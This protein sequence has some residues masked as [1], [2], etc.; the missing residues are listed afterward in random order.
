MLI[1]SHCHLSYDGFSDFILSRN[2]AVEDGF[3]KTESI[4]Q[5]ACENDVKYFINIGTH[6]SDFSKLREICDQFSNVFMAIGIHPDNSHEHLTKFSE[7][8]LRDIFCEYCVLQK[9]IAIGEIGLDYHINHNID[10][11]KRLFHMQLEY[12]EEFGLPVSIHSRDAWQD[13]ISVLQ[14]H[15]NV[16]GVIH[17]FSGE[18]EFTEQVLKMP[19][20]FGVGGT[21]TFKN[22]RQLQSSLEMIPLDRILLETDAPFLAPV[23]FRGQINEPAFIVKVAEK[24]AEIKNISIE[25]VAV[26]T[27]R[28][29]FRLF[30]K[31][32][33]LT[34][35]ATR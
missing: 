9:T 6:V 23:P 30:R 3:Y 20:F 4:L 8:E 25:E 31:A 33:E 32:Y 21:L 2:A 11:Q 27:T 34:S 35:K 15:S 5:R 12:A 29:F 22:N 16:N 19:F 14:E 26:Q 1:D 24:I 17:C 10:E 13:I 7:K 28:N 18:K